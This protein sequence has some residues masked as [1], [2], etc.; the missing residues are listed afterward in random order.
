MPMGCI[1]ECPAGDVRD[2]NPAAYGFGLS[3]STEFGRA[4]DRP[5]RRVARLAQPPALC[6]RRSVCRSSSCSTTWRMRTMPRWICSAPCWVRQR[7]ATRSDLPLPEWLGAYL[8]PETGLA[9]RI[10]AASAG[11]CGCVTVIPRNCSI[12][13]PTD[14]PAADGTRLRPVQDGLWMDRPRENQS[15]RCAR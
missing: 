2:G 9:V 5:W 13:G 15:S 8:E 10:D 4:V 6:A 3:R 11:N 12:C 1:A 14:R 7:P